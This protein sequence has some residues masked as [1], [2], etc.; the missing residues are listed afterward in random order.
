MQKGLLKF[1][2]SLQLVWSRYVEL[3]ESI[4]STAWPKMQLFGAGN[5]K[6]DW[7]FELRAPNFNPLPHRA[8]NFKPLAP[9]FWKNPTVSA[10]SCCRRQSTY[11]GTQMAHPPTL[12]AYK[13]AHKFRKAKVTK[14]SIEATNSRTI[15]YFVSHQPLH[16]GPRVNQQHWPQRCWRWL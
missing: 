8:P 16:H 11:G 4:L 3:L 7:F 14:A 9:N 2:A 1:P 6:N 5:S 12:C 15:T 13:R 10:K